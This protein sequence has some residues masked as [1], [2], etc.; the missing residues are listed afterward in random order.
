MPNWMIEKLADAEY[1]LVRPSLVVLL[2]T[3][4]CALAHQ[5]LEG[6]LHFQNRLDIIDIVWITAALIFG[7]CHAF[8]FGFV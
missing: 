6:R 5:G 8:D 7:N 1:N 4:R 2:Q 3:R